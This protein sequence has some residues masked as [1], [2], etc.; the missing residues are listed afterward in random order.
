MAQDG[1]HA[2]V[3]RLGYN[4]LF[5]AAQMEDDRKFYWIKTK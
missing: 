3:R 5:Y 2:D 4:S 1:L